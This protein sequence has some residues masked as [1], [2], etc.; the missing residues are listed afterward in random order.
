M[1]DLHHEQDKQIV[2]RNARDADDK[3]RWEY[4]EDWIDLSNESLILVRRRITK[5]D[6]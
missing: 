3:W 2:R 5:E 1:T 6:D 4:V